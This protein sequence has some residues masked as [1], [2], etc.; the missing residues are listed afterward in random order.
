MKEVTFKNKNK[1]TFLSAI[2][3]FTLLV[4]SF[5]ALLGCSGCSAKENEDFTFLFNSSLDGYVLTGGTPNEYGELIIPKRH[6]RRYV[7]SVGSGA[8]FLNDTIV[9]VFIPNSIRSIGHSSFRE[10]LNLKEVIFEENSSLSFVDSNAFRESSISKINLPNSLQRIESSAFYSTNLTSVRLPDDLVSVSNDTFARSKIEEIIIPTN[11]AGLWGRSSYLLSY[12]LLFYANP[13]K[14]IIIEDG[15][16]YH[17]NDGNNLIINNGLETISYVLL[18]GT[19]NSQ[20]VIPDFI[21]HIAA[22]AFRSFPTETIRI[23]DSIVFIGSQAI[24]S[25]VV[26]VEGR[27]EIPTY[28]AYNWARGNPIINFV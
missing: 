17:R 19:L 11:L 20:E 3:L 12:S 21:T 26:Y 15:N 13:L 22:G 18:S 25:R 8:F 14:R 9:S 23:P 6:R 2:L 10:M 5:L 1:F 28:W 24:N 7:V 4:F 16:V 27:T